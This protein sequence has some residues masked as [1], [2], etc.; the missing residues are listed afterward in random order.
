M[1]TYTF[2]YISIFVGIGGGSTCAHKYIDKYSIRRLLTAVILY[3]PGSFYART[4]VRCPCLS[5]RACDRY[6][7][8]I[9][10][11]VWPCKTILSPDDNMR[12]V[13]PRVVKSS[14][15]LALVEEVDG[16]EEGARTRWYDKAA[17]VMRKNIKA[18]HLRACVATQEDA[19]EEDGKEVGAP[20][21]RVVYFFPDDDNDDDEAEENTNEASNEDCC[22]CVGD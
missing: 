4:S 13:F 19:G 12:F 5:A 7:A 15:V 22:G 18:T 9:E 11:S 6:A 10:G 3:R 21:L 17:T 16:E 20:G 14:D 8:V 2:T 1:Y